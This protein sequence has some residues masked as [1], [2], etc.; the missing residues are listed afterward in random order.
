MNWLQRRMLRPRY[1]NRCVLFSHKT[2][3]AETTDEN[4]E[5]S[6]CPFAFSN[7]NLQIPF[8]RSST[9]FPSVYIPHLTRALSVGTLVK[10]E[11]G[12][13]GRDVCE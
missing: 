5:I 3:R 4:G 7:L 6:S 1:V 9:P 2:R 12:M 11:G 8:A 13:G 10:G